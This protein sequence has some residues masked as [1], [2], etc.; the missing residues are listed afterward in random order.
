MHERR[1][2][3]NLLRTRLHQTHVTREQNVFTASERGLDVPRHTRGP[4][5]LSIEIL[6]FY[7]CTGKLAT[8]CAASGR[9]AH[10]LCT[11]THAARSLLL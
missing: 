5:T 11:N 4:G 10:V 8:L 7:N 3:E 6:K 2:D 1:A 9:S